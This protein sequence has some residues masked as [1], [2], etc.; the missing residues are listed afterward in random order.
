MYNK[1]LNGKLFALSTA[2]LLV[3]TASPSAMALTASGTNISNNATISYDVS[4]TP[5]TAIVSN[6]ETFMVDAKVDLTVAGTGGNI[7][8]TPNTTA[9]SLKF[10]VTNTGNEAFDFAL[11]AVAGT[12]NFTPTNVAIYVD[13]GDGIRNG[14]DTLTSTIT[15]LAAGASRVVFIQSDIPASATNTQTA[16][17]SL[18]AVA[19]L[20]N[21]AGAI[22][23][24]A[25]DVKATKQY[26]YADAA[27]TATG[28]LTRDKTHSVNLTYTAVTSALTIS[29]TST[30][31]W[32]PVNLGVSPLHIPGAIVEYTIT[33]SN[34]A[35][36]AQ[37]DAIV[38]TD[39]LASNLTI[40]PSSNN[41][42]AGR[43]IEVTS[44]N[45]YS[46]A[47]TALS[48]ISDADQGNVAGQL[49]TV[50]GI[51]L[52]ASQSATVKIRAEIQ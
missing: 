19:A 1:H 48:D 9:Q 34:A 17:Y 45:L 50:N 30:V 51:V 20:A 52:S 36:G 22:P 14:A 3:L 47:A 16:T 2:S 12:L 23:A 33:I 26:V 40:P 46:G 39:T 18:K 7:N 13:D 44:P 35:G 49:V 28:D 4:S 32:D 21:A 31:V 38:L 11:S 37:A 29:K 10:T 8:V 43:S 6:T 24:Q 27:G 15:N 5:Q 25:A 42:A 41:F